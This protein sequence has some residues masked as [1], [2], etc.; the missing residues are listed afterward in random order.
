M[1]PRVSLGVL[2]DRDRIEKPVEVALRQRY[3]VPVEPVD[4]PGPF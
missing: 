3:A 4:Q 1:S 2:R